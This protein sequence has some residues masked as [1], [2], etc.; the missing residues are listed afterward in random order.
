MKEG[1]LQKSKKKVVP[2]RMNAMKENVPACGIE[3]AGAADEPGRKAGKRSRFIEKRGI[4]R[5]GVRRKKRRA[6]N[7]LRGVHR[8]AT[9]SAT[10]SSGD[11]GGFHSGGEG[12]RKENIFTVAFPEK[13][14]FRPEGNWLKEKKTSLYGVRPVINRKKDCLDRREKERLGKKKGQKGPPLHPRKKGILLNKKGGCDSQ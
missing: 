6:G 3:G 1:K 12:R 4:P 7:E 13:R 9:G 5:N 14:R 8:T 2:P 10:N 11:R